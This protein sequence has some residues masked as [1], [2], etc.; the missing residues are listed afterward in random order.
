MEI[1]EAVKNWTN[2]SGVEVV[3]DLVGAAYLKA[4]LQIRWLVKGRLIFVGTTSGSR[5]EMDYSIAMGKAPPD[6]GHVFAHA[7]ARREGN[8]DQIVSRSTSCRYSPA[9]QCVR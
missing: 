2:G 9:A 5:A 3:L 6:H 8:R 4:N 1:A 7:L